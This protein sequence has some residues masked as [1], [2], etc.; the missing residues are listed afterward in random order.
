MY[1][2]RL[3]SAKNSSSPSFSSSFDPGY[4]YPS[5][6]NGRLDLKRLIDLMSRN[7]F[8]RRTCSGRKASVPET[9]HGGVESEFV[10]VGIRVI[11][12][13]LTPSRNS[14]YWSLLCPS[15][16]QFL[17]IFVC[18]HSFLSSYNKGTFIGSRRSVVES[19]F[20]SPKKKATW[21]RAGNIGAD[22]CRLI[23]LMSA[24]KDLDLECW[25]R[26]FL[27]AQLLLFQA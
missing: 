9:P 26:P 19:Y 7:T 21:R 13:T 4:L 10:S 11:G 23:A 27:L 24:L 14:G 5:A 6:R 20:P 2:L 16:W 22:F 8:S 25:G 17:Q 12:P 1:Y 18:L 15:C 3:T